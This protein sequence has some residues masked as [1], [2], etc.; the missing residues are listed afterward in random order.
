MKN[1]TNCKY[2]P[3]FTALLGI[4][5]F[6]LRWLLYSLTVDNRNLIP[7]W[8]PLEIGLWIVTAAAVLLI[9]FQIR[10]LRHP[11][12]DANRFRPAPLAA[13]GSL[14]LAGGILAAVLG[15]GLQLSDMEMV[16]DL[17]GIVAT[18][19]MVAV[20]VYRWRGLEP[21][22]LLHGVVCVFFAL[23]MVT[24]YQSWS[25]NPQL[26]DYVF[27]LFSCIGLMLFAFY[28]GCLEAGMGKLR[29]LP[30]VGLLTT[31]CCIVALSGTEFTLLYLSGAVWT[32]T[33]LLGLHT[34]E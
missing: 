12:N 15:D 10:K 19:A 1:R 2:L 16:R 9:V 4:A 14:V 34:G 22:F 33:N 8:H 25:S 27:T 5:G 32:L 20:T 28:H 11:H 29:L 30:A 26:M 3:A 21:F 24:C 7:L 17:L 13:A 23:H 18:L 6:A 31:Y